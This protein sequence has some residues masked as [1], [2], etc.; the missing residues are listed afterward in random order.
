MDH[1]RIGGQ[2]ARLGRYVVRI[3]QEQLLAL[4][5]AA[6]DAIDQPVIHRRT[7]QHRDLLVMEGELPVRAGGEVKRPYLRQPRT[8]QVEQRLSIT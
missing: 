1:R 6:V 8:T 5:A 2:F 7:P 3:D 4:I